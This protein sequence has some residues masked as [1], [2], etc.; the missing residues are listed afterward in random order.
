MSVIK[1]PKGLRK[2]GRTQIAVR[3]PEHLFKDIIVMAKKE[4]PPKD[5]NDMVVYLVEC[6]K[7][8][9]TESDKL[10]AA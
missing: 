1:Y 6:G 9:L 4:K 2:N 5:F 7:L 8:C 3:F 10:E